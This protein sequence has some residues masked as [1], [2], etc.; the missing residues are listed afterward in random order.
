MKIDYPP[1][2]VTW[3]GKLA[4]LYQWNMYLMDLGRGQVIGKVTQVFSEL[5]SFMVVLKYFG[6]SDMSLGQI[7]FASM[8]IGIFLVWITGFVYAKLNMDVVQQIVVTRRNPLMTEMHKKITGVNY[9]RKKD[10][11][12]QGRK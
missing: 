11:K 7:L 3:K 9:H 1:E 5:T 2:I 4:Y 6:F 12:R 10:N 8:F